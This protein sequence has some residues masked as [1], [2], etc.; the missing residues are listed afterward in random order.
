MLRLVYTVEREA[1]RQPFVTGTVHIG[2]SDFLEVSRF[3]LLA[4][5]GD[6]FCQQPLFGSTRL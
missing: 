1:T 3:K 2:L 4:H 5:G 6:V